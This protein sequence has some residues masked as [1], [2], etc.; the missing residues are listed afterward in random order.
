M[1]VI[2]NVLKVVTLSQ[3]KHMYIIVLV[4]A[5]RLSDGI[6]SRLISGC[7]DTK[8]LTNAPL[9]LKPSKQ[10]SHLCSERSYSNMDFEDLY[11]FN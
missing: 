8:W 5:G 9:L 4:T 10:L 11:K 1:T 7:L 6:E 3:C 2:Y